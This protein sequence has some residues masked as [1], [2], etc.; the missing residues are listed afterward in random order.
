MP[1][2][3]RVETLTDSGKIN[4]IVPAQTAKEAREHPKETRVTV[5]PGT[6]EHE[7]M[8][9]EQPHSIDGV[10]PNTER[11]RQQTPVNVSVQQP[12]AGGLTGGY[13]TIANMSAVAVLM[14]FMLWIYRDSK[15]DQREYMSQMRE[16]RIADR[17]DSK[18]ADA[19]TVA[20]LT[21][22]SGKMDATIAALITKLD[23]MVVSA[24]GLV[25]S[26]NALVAAMSTEMKQARQEISALVKILSEKKPPEGSDPP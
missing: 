3:T 1:E 11:R 16:D 6:S 12:N 26:N 24:A 19:A 13:A 25:A 5:T 17:S 10:S 18:S 4:V 22:L 14:I 7:A 21:A 20:A 9:E 23:A 8:I 15:A 2:K